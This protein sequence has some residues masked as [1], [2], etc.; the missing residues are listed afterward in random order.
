[1]TVQTFTGLEIKDLNPRVMIGG[2]LNRLLGHLINLA[3]L[4][5]P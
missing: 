3:A 1:M 4:W 5:I 2:F